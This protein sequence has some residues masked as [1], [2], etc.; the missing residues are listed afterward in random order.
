M[1]TAS[2]SAAC[3]IEVRTGTRVGLVLERRGGTWSGY[4]C[5]QFDPD[6][7][8]AAAKPLPAPSGRGPVALVVGGEFGD[9]R[10]IAL[11]ARGRTLAYGK[12][13][14]R[15]GLVSI[16]PG[17]ERLAEL[18]YTETGTTLVIRNTRTLRILGRHLVTLPGGRY[19]QRLACENGSGT[20]VILFARR[21]SGSAAGSALYRVA[22][23]RVGAIWKGAAHDAAITSTVVYLSAGIRA[24]NLLRVDLRGHRV[25]QLADLPDATTSLALNKS[26]TLL[27]GIQARQDRSAQVVYVDLRSAS[28]KVAT[29]RFPANQ[30]QAQVFWLASG[31]LVFVPAF[32]NTV[33]VLDKS[34]RTRS[35]IRWTAATA[36]LS[37]SR[38][39][40]TDAST[41]L[42]RAELPS[43]PT[44]IVRRLP[45]RPTLIVATAR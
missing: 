23:G 39:F 5:W 14:G 32:G 42:L 18:A 7:L 2:N 9:V 19:A 24:K 11:D 16:C 6:E 4:L 38:L 21:P 12:G 13:G 34:L 31:R 36:V 29:A 45:G 8:L 1:S 33:R 35:R 25:S 22:S 10:L 40:G 37:G 30:G 27:A 26:G 15:A 41:A 3:G 43:G 44:R 17:K 20:A 28:G